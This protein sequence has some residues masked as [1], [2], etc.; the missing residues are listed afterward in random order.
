MERTFVKPKI[1]KDLENSILN[2]EENSLEKF[3]YHIDKVGTPLIEKFEDLEEYDLVT[4]IYKEEKKLDN[5]VL[6]PPV[7]MRKLEKCIM[8]KVY[9]TDVWY[10]SYKVKNDISF[11]YQFSP[12]DPLDNDWNRRWKN[13]KGDI[14]NKK[15]ILHFDKSINVERMVPYVNLENARKKFFVNKNKNSKEG[16]IKEYFIFSN[17]L[18]ENRKFKVYFP[19]EYDENKK[20]KLVVLNDGIEYLRILNAKNILDNL[21]QMKRI[22]PVIAVFIESTNKRAENLKCS[23]NFSKFIC[24][25]LMEFL[26]KNTSISNKPKDKVIGGY[27]LGGLEASYVAL[28]YSN[29]FGNVLS[30]SGSYWYKKD[31]YNKNE[32]WIVNEFKKVHKLPINFYI[33]VGSIEPKVS[34]IDTN[35]EFKNN[36]INLGYNVKFDFFGS[37]HDYLYWDETLA[38]GLIYFLN[39]AID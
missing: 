31:N 39:I 26:Y 17:I 36:L 29:I 11:T 37:G 34:M 19:Y 6:I 35:I 5:V 7:G 16:N 24:L 32:P 18:N 25:E 30:Q 8:N 23:D 20:Y 3:W 2:K 13:V 4:L 21:I 10:I 1:I 14:F 12:N 15:A 27:S 33:N 38:D 28:K 22:P 9:G